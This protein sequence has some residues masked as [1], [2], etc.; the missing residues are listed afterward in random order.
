VGIRGR[1]PRRHVPPCSSPAGMPVEMGYASTLRTGPQ[2]GR[3][4]RKTRIQP[5]AR[6]RRDHHGST[7]GPRQGIQTPHRFVGD[8]QLPGM[9]ERRRP[10]CITRRD[11]EPRRQR[12]GHADPTS[13][14][15][16][17]RRDRGANGPEPQAPV[18]GRGRSGHPTAFMI[19]DAVRYMSVHSWKQPDSH[20]RSRTSQPEKQQP[21]RRGIPSSRAVSAGSGRCWVR[22]NVG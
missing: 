11:G 15:K 4:C 21:A 14:L 8:A 5:M 22:T 10:C 13:P 7:A 17:R 12:A 16:T 6:P 19:A 20:R 2:C 9:D 18:P 3:P 1:S